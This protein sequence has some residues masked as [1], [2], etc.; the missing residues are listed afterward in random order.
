MNLVNSAFLWLSMAFLGVV[1]W[2]VLSA[3]SQGEG[4]LGSTRSGGAEPERVQLIAG[5][6]IAAAVYAA[7]CLAT[8]KTGKPA[9][10]EPPSWMLVAAGGSHLV[11]L[12]GK[13]SR[14]R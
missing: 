10:V 8:L 6:V 12:L 11:Y 9:L 3:M 7:D 14:R 1:A 4:L 5:T 2:K 13:T